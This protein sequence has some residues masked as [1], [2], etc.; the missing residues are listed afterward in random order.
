MAYLRH[1]QGLVTG[2]LV[3]MLGAG[4]AA[5]SQ[6]AP[7]P[8]DQDILAILTN[9][10]DV[11]RRHV[12]VVVGV[13]EPAGRRIVSRGTFSRANTRP[14][15]GDTVFE[16]GS[17]TKVFTSLLLA[18]MVQRGEVALDDPVAQFL[19]PSVKVP[20]REATAITLQ[21]LST[22]TSG[23]PRLPTNLVV[24]NPD[25]PYA[26][27][28]VE[29]LHAFLSGYT[30]TRGI[31]SQFEYSNFGVGLLGHALALR[32]KSAYAPLIAARITGPLGMKQ[33][34]VQLSNDMTG[35]LASGHNAR[36]EPAG[37]W[38]LPSLA[39]AGALRSTANDLL[40]FL[41]AFIGAT[42]SDLAPAMAR[43]L[44]VRRPAGAGLI[45]ALGWQLI[46]RDGVEFVWH[47][48]ATGGYSAFVAYVPS[49]SV[50]IVAL[51]NNS[52][53]AGSSVDDLGL[54]LLDPKVPLA[55]PVPIR[56]KITVAPEVLA[57]YAGSYELMPGFVAVVAHEDGRLYVTPQ[58]Q[59]RHEI[60]AE[61]ERRFFATIADVQFTFDGDAP[62]PV[63][64]MTLHQAGRATTGKRV[65]A[66]ATPAPAREVVAVAPGVLEGYV[67]QYRFTP[68]M[69]ITVT[70]QD[71]RLFAQAT[72]QGAF[73]L[74]AESETRF[75]A[76]VAGI[77]VSFDRDA[78]GR[79][80][81]LNIR[82][83][84]VTSQLKRIE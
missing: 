41:S 44:S 70:R 63:A 82:Q 26:G 5:S 62:G 2:L 58:G 21:D 74:F 83:G 59:P 42:K 16:I 60:F 73:E 30:L 29:N 27:Y 64:T 15:D 9:R 68:A 24:T 76:K 23:L 36:L 45:S 20:M 53:P 80:A 38:D 11:D 28:S 12:G 10:V 61:T 43:M 50:G 52:G 37:N 13:I 14:V 22:H 65:T 31:G 56:T 77:E 81:T 46:N 79:A 35:R 54:H 4:V 47:S 69:V 75:F 66:S 34:A 17:V 78:T 84:G 1:V 32:A 49:R 3:A 72:G 39:G 7:I 18:D 67:G 48:G 8:S 71:A 33:T 6:N 40:Q 51:A 57:R 19:P 25:N 55:K